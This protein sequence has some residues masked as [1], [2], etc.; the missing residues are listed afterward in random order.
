MAKHHDRAEGASASFTS[1]NDI[2]MRDENEKLARLDHSNNSEESER[3]KVPEEMEMGDERENA[4]LLP[5][6]TAEKVEPKRPAWLGTVLWTT[7]NTLA[8]IGIVFT[9]KAIF[10]DPSLKLAQLTFAAFHFTITW[11]TLY[12]LSRPRFA[13]FQP[14]RVTITEIMPLSVAMA[15]NVILPNLSLAFSSVTFYQV[16]RILLT[17]TVAA[18]NFVLYQQKLPRLALAALVPAC[19]GVGI[20]SYYDSLP[21]ADAN[22][23]TTSSLGIIFAFS[24]IFASSLYTVWISSF[25][26]KLQMSSMQLLFNQAPV[27]AFLLLYVIPFIDTFPTWSTVPVSRWV[28]ILMSGAFASLINISQFFIIAQTGPVS[29]TVVGHLKTCTIIALGWATSGRSVG[30]KSVL[31]VF[32]AVGG[33]IAYSYVMIKEKQKAAALTARGQ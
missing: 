18:M 31:G 16:A 5:A 28:M 19:L 7:I 21:A 23:K 17:P 15:L 29:S 14:R 33:I 6:E 25:H 4:G 8:T 11:F 10:S 30:D 13:F 20:V 2:E 24:G 12:V 26:R 9:N 32:I 3:T 27:S 1:N 22:V